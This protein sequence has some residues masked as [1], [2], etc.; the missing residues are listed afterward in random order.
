MYIEIDPSDRAAKISSEDTFTNSYKDSFNIGNLNTSSDCSID[1]R[2]LNISFVFECSHSQNKKSNLIH[3]Q[4]MKLVIVNS[5]GKI[6]CEMKGDFRSKILNTKRLSF[7]PCT[8]L[9]SDT[10]KVYFLDAAQPSDSY[11]TTALN[12]ET[13][14]FSINKQKEL[15]SDKAN[16]I[17]I[18]YDTNINY[19]N[20][21]PPQG[22][23]DYHSSLL[24]VSLISPH[25]LELTPPLDGIQYNIQ[26]NRAQP[27]AQTK[28]QISWLGSDTTG[29]YFLALPNK[30]GEIYSINELFGDNTLGPD[31][32]YAANG[33]L[34]LAKYDSNNDGQINS[35]DEVFA[36]LRLWN[37]ANRDGLAS[38]DEVYSLH[39]KD[40][41]VIDLNYDDDHFEADEY[42]NLTLMKAI[43]KT[44]DGKMHLMFD[45]WLRQLD[46]VTE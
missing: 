10:Y 12:S 41:A 16:L 21:E 42:S 19:D 23:C 14:T 18:S 37:D 6:A 31:G 36:K 1:N 44:T 38:T 30:S 7:S 25:G 34:A 26:G 43:V 2:N 20:I 29:V 46:V 39:D 4:N 17:N 33:F 11:A 32:R 28:K 24:A 45:L 8:N 15:C 13:L 22:H 40:I 9:T 3:I 5:A 27:V 35:D